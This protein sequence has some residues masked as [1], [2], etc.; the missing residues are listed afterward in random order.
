[1][2]FGYLTRLMRGRPLK[3]S[4][5]D[6][7]LLPVVC[8]S[9]NKSDL[10]SGSNEFLKIHLCPG[11]VQP[12]TVVLLAKKGGDYDGHCKVFYFSGF[13]R[14]GAWRF[15][16]CEKGDPSSATT[17]PDD[18]VLQIRFRPYGDLHP[19]QPALRRVFPFLDL[20]PF[21]TLTC[22]EPAARN[23]QSRSTDFVIPTRWSVS[24]RIIFSAVNSEAPR[25]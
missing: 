18:R 15:S 1:M 8:Y 14:C 16:L 20:R 13:G 9:R 22:E 11:L 24:T 19:P 4:G 17:T 2:W 25:M 23:R 5:E 7:P 21:A 3:L 12:N 6:G 10:N